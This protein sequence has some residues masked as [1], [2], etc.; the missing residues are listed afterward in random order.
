MYG[1][2]GDCKVCFANQKKEHY[3]NNKE[4]YTERSKKYKRNN[5]E[6]IL[7]KAKEYYENN[8][9]QISEKQKEYKKNN[10]R[11][12]SEQGREYKRQRRQNDPIFRMVC[13]YRSRTSKT[14]TN[15]AKSTIELLGCTGIELANHLEKQFQPGMTHDNYGEWHIDH[16]RPI[17]SFDLSDPKDADKCFHYTNLQPLWAEENMSK[18]DKLT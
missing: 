14:Y 10:R 17:A 6:K 3:K 12:I 13:N 1:V 4:C 11:K 7:E 16:I 2:R 15:K 18:G 5:R 8:K 9:E